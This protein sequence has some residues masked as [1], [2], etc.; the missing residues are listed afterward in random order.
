LKYLAETEVHTYAFSVAANAILSFVPAVV[1]M[2]TISRYILHSRPMYD[3]LFDLLQSYLPTWNYLDKREVVASLQRL[4]KHHHTIEAISVIML[5]ISSTGVFEPLEVA[6]NKVWGFKTNRNYLMNQVV[7]LGLALGCGVLALGSV[8]LTAEMQPEAT[9]YVLRL[10]QPEAQN[11]VA[12][13]PTGLTTAK[14]QLSRAAQRRQRQQQ[15]A[16]QVLT[17]ANRIQATR[18][19]VIKATQWVTMKTFAMTTSILIF[20]L[21]YWLLPNGKVKALDVL[22]AAFATGVSLEVAKYAFM[23]IM[24]FLDFKEDYGPM[25]YIPVTLIFWAFTAGLLMLGG[26][27]LSA[28]GKT[29]ETAQN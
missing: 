2:G 8:A 18:G 11:E 29:K 28:Y 27:H 3:L 4:V 20:F 22:P 14:T 5:L 9:Q 6:L 16:A 13:A 15:Q 12:P 25:F 1:L 17:F 26:A 23:G 21:I 7:S 24:H 10:A 19:W